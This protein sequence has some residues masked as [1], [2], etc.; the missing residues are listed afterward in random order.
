MK[1]I[2][3]LLAAIACST[4]PGHAQMPRDAAEDARREVARRGSHVELTGTVRADSLVRALAPPADDSHKWFITLIGKSGDPASD[5]YRTMIEHGKDPALLA[6]VDVSD[7]AKSFSHYQYRVW[8]LQGTQRDWLAPLKVP[9]EKYGLPIVLVQPPRSGQYGDPATMVK[10]IHGLHKA[11]EL[12]ARLKDGIATYLRSLEKPIQSGVPQT[13]IGVP[14]PFNV[15][16][17]NAPGPPAVMPTTPQF[18]WPQSTPAVLSID[19]IRQACPDAT[20]DFVVEQLMGK[21]TNVENV[22]LQWMLAQLKAERKAAAS[23]P[24][25]LLPVPDPDRETTVVPKRPESHPFSSPA[26]QAPE[27]LAIY[28]MGTLLAGLAIGVIVGKRGDV[29]DMTLMSSHQASLRPSTNQEQTEPT[30]MPN[31]GT[32]TSWRPSSGKG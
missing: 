21:A 24:P 16:P 32:N 23:D 22:K 2:M 19:Q 3:Y 27:R 6:W 7:P 14:P 18:D 11:D 28:L 13:E 15:N 5:A 8:D 25:Q 20:S 29:R 17:P 1:W 10:M 9:V 4:I 31:A 12:A 30:D 26:T